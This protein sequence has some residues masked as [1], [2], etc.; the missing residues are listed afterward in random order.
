[1][2]NYLPNLIIAGVGKAGTTSL[3]SYLSKH[4]DIC[5]SNIKE[6]H[7]F[8]P[9]IDDKELQ[10]IDD[11]KKYFCHCDDHRYILEAT[12]RY[13][14]GGVKVAR[15]IYERLGPIKIILVFRDPVNRLF[16]FYKHLKGTAW[17]Q[18]VYLLMNM[19][20]FVMGCLKK[21]II[22]LKQSRAVFMMIIWMIG[23]LFLMVLLK[24]FFLRI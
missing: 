10:P 17:I 2:K 8:S 15:A 9:L 13:F 22:L 20:D 11:Y 7:Y 14:Y 6:T 24:L 16:S 1:M 4:P 19:L 12:P 3:F 23:M 18:R 5:T 21:N